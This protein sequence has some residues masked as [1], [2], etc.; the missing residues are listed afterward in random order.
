MKCSITVLIYSKYS[1]LSLSQL[2]LS[3]KTAYLDVKIWSLFYHGNI[4]IKYCGKEEKLL[5]RSNF[6]SFQQYF[7]YVSNFGSPIR[8][9]F[10]KCGCLI[11][12]FL[13]SANLLCRDR[14]SW[15]ISESPLNLEITRVDCNQRIIPFHTE[16]TAWLSHWCSWFQIR[17]SQVRILLEAKSR[18]WLYSTL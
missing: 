2:C 4:V 8:Y 1:R 12:F 10:V 3:W 7:Q 11:Y 13:S 17:M 16:A 14:I 9:S 18:S 15:G 5:L 6:S